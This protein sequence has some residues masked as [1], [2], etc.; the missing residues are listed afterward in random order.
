[1]P[2]SGSKESLDPKLPEPSVG[3]QRG[4]RRELLREK[5]NLAATSWPRK[6]KQHSYG[7]S[8]RAREGGL[9]QPGLDGAIDHPSPAVLISVGPTLR[10]RFGLGS[11]RKVRTRAAMFP[12]QPGINGLGLSVTNLPDSRPLRG[13]GIGE[14][15]AGRVGVDSWADAN[16]GSRPSRASE[17]V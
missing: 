17:M 1:L 11:L 2:W 14:T 16:M 5:G 9:A 3:R 4:A 15:M 6:P 8:H 7:R 13:E 10:R 12:R